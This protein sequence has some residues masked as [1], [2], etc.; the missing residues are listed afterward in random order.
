MISG[1]THLPE[2]LIALRRKIDRGTEFSR[3]WPQNPIA[4]SKR[5]CQGCKPACYPKVLQLSFLGAKRRVV[6]LSKVKGDFDDE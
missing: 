5:L 6:T 3:E 4:L 2:L 1:R